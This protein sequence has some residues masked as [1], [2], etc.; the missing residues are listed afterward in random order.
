MKNLLSYRWFAVIT[1]T[2]LVLQP[3][4]FVYAAR[5]S[6]GEIIET[7]SSRVERSSD[8]GL[9]AEQSIQSVSS[10]LD[11]IE[12]RTVRGARGGRKENEILV[13]MKGDEKASLITIED[14]DVDAAI[15]AYAEDEEVEFAEPN[16]LYS[17]SFVP[18]DTLYNPYQ[19]N[20]DN[21]VYGG[22]EAEQGWDIGNGAGAVVAVLDSGIAYEDYGIYR[23]A[24]DFD[25]ATFVPGYDFV[26]NDAHPNDDLGHGT[27]VAGT[28][29][30]Q[31]N[32]AAGVAGLAYGAKLMPVKVISAAGQ[33]EAS[34]I[35]DGIRFAAD[36]GAD[37]INMSLG[38]PSI[39][40]T[41][42]DALIYAHGKG[43]VIV[44]AAGNANI[45]GV[46][47]PAAHD[48]YV[49]SVGATRYDEQ[50]APYSNYGSA[51]DFVAPGGDASVDQNGD[52]YS[53]GI[54][55]V[56]FDA[57]NPASFAVYFYQGTSMA[58]PH[59]SALAAMIIGKGI[60]SGPTA[61]EQVLAATSD[62]LGAAGWDQYFGNG[63]INVG[64]ALGYSAVDAPPTV[65][66][67]APSNGATVKGN[68]TI[69]ANASDD[70]GVTR[71]DF[72]VDGVTVGSDT[73]SSYS[74]TWNSASVA[75]GSHTI[76]AVATDSAGQ[77]T[78][79]AART[80]TVDNIPDSVTTLF[81]DGFASGTLAQ[82]WTESNEYDWN[83]EKPAEKQPSG[84]SSTNTVAH[85]DQCTTSSGCFLTM[86]N[87]IDTTGYATTTL[88]FKRYV[89]GAI[90]NNEFLRV[91]VW[92]G[93]AWKQVKRWTNGSGDNDRWQTITVN[94]TGYKN[95]AFKVRFVAKMSDTS[96][97]VEIE[98]VKITGT[99]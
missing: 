11:R 92:N 68:V 80:V 73:T 77:T 72:K 27:H 95:S 54:P 13:K 32:N 20:F 39:S 51:L 96:E 71:V 31:T 7:V 63:I 42:L 8:R 24:P 25:A 40:Q 43:V 4:A 22:V 62:N 60:A 34:W 18:N 64:R 75:D 9:G 53:D 57:S 69:W 14:G 48:E 2:T 29:A 21:A 88:T 17:V 45:N 85:A 37:V 1:A 78:T 58:T 56:T 81:E 36:N 19:W 44:A 66:L 38:G 49:I 74:Y 86:T 89:D 84:K 3:V 47:Y 65:A 6:A 91:D 15:A 50:R 16:Y 52:G 70:K 61:V 67:T 83:I 98:D 5:P 28:I 99:K 94:I 41:I 87:G 10:A 93:S 26:N 82:K 35:A 12:N 97:E 79:S 59:V 33:G 90:D 76:T 46:Y 55:Q 30:Q 23:K